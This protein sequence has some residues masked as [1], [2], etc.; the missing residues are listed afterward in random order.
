MCVRE[1]CI[2]AEKVC[3]DEQGGSLETQERCLCTQEY[4]CK[5]SQARERWI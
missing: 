4:V 5:F 3:S 1:V 2:R